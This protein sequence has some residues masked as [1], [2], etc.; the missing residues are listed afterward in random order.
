MPLT[1]RS[2]HHYLAPVADVEATT[3]GKGGWTTLEISEEM[4]LVRN[5]IDEHGGQ[6]DDR[7]HGRGIKVAGGEDTDTVNGAG[8]ERN[9]KP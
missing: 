8:V 5:C 9:F 3:R 6:D 7:G 1:V 2:A 4:V